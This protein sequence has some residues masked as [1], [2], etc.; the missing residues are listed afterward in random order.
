MVFNLQG[1]LAN[2]KKKTL[3]NINVAMDP[4]SMPAVIIPAPHDDTTGSKN[5]KKT[6]KKSGRQEQ[7]YSRKIILFQTEKP[8]EIVS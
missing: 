2:H 8:V 1:K 3:K 7:L 5:S 6:R 4:M